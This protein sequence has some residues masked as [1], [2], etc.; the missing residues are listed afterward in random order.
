MME[1]Y[2]ALN[3]ITSDYQQMVALMDSRLRG[4][5]G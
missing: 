4:N 5:D 3:F 1:L 2:F